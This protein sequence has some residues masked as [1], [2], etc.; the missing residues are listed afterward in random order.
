VEIS[1]VAI[2]QPDTVVYHAILPKIGDEE[3]LHITLNVR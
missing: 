1:Q 2:I 3:T